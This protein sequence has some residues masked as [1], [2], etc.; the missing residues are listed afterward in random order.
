MEILSGLRIPRPLPLS[1]SN[2]SAC[3]YHCGVKG[4]FPFFTLEAVSSLSGA[5]SCISSTIVPLNN[6]FPISFTGITW[7]E[8]MSRKNVASTIFIRCNLLHLAG[9]PTC[10]Y[11]DNV[12]APIEKNDEAG[13][14]GVKSFISACIMVFL[15]LV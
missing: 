2:V 1:T 3:I 12:K 9:L 4:S 15:R 14:R 5:V 7:K 6:I 11:E 10:K 13:T 8:K